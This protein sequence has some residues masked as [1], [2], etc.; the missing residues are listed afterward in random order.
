MAGYLTREERKEYERA[1]RGQVM[2]EARDHRLLI[3]WLTKVQP[4]SLAKFYA[5]KARL[6][7][8]YPKR[9]DL[10]K[11]QAFV[12]FMYEEGNVVKLQPE[13]M[14]IPLVDIFQP[15]SKP[16]QE[17]QSLGPEQSQQSLEPEQSQRSSLSE[18][19]LFSLSNDEVDELMKGLEGTDQSQQSLLSEC[20]LFSLSNDEV[21][22]LIKGLEGIGQSQRSLLSEHSLPGF[23]D[24]EVDE[25]LKMDV[26]DF[27][28]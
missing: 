21:D 17:R 12:Q 6:Q 10:S 15:S 22:E 25:L 2:N 11:S 27:L 26:D 13:R 9:K 3:G 19:D 8:L 18:R 1:R 20:D 7:S 5:F 23:S 28:V 14:T 4:D 24:Q 16:K